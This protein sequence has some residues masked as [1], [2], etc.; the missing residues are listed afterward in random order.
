MSLHPGLWP[1]LASAR[2]A[3]QHRT[4]PVAALLLRAMSADRVSAYASASAAHTQT[5]GGQ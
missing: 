3:C 5:V 1:G 2:Y 4:G